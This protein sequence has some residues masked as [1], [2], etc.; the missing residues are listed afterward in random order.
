[1]KKK[2]LSLIVSAAMVMTVFAGMTVTASAD[3]AAA[4]AAFTVYLQG[5][6][7]TLT[8]EKEYTTEQ[9]AA[10]AE[11][12]SIGG[13]YYK[14]DVWNGITSNQ[15]VTVEA[16]LAD[17]GINKDFVT[18]LYATEVKDG[19][20]SSYT[21]SEYKAY[22][23][24]PAYLYGETKGSDAAFTGAPTEQPLAI[25]MAAT[26][27]ADTSYNVIA[28]SLAADDNAGKRLAQGISGIAVTVDKTAMDTAAAKA[29]KVKNL[30]V[31]GSKAKATVKYKKTAG[32]EKYKVTYSKSKKFTKA[33]VKYT[34][35]TSYTLKLKKG[36]YYV[37]IAAGKKVDGKNVYGK[38]SG[39]KKVVVK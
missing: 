34:T 36:T 9:F 4:P 33:T 17:A 15:Y 1:M 31:K 24:G 22:L 7:G 8:A 26:T 19:A 39:Y 6:D 2:I 11:T 16:L 28:G 10:L 13:F 23:A 3:D 29:L 32:A 38:Y 5:E 37:K 18:A 21:K 27:S 30:T 25:Y 14:G 35:K 12:G 20:V